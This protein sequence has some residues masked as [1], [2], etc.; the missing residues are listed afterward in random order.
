MN[1]SYAM[2]LWRADLVRYGLDDEALRTGKRIIA[3]HAGWHRHYHGLDHLAFLFGEIEARADQI[4]EPERLTYAA[5]FHDAIYLSWR[6]DNEAASAS[7]A[8]SALVAMGATPDMAAR[9]QALIQR[10]ANHAEGGAD[11][12]DNLF[13]DMDCAILG[14]PPEVYARYAKQVRQEYWWVPGRA[15]RKGRSAFLREQLNRPRLFHT[16]VYDSQLGAQAR[17]NMSTEL[18]RL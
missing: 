8:Q 12:D 11:H 6:K 16:E 4:D 2:T 9:V 18:A 1:R 14:A 5:W 3:N 17:E 15:Y 7:W 10:T 13:L